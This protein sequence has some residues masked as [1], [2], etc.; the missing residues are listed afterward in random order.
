MPELLLELF[1]EEIPARMQRRAAEDLR[2]LVTDALVERGFLYEGARAYATPR[3]LA[4][5]VVGLPPE[6]KSVREERRGPR[7][8]APEAAIQGFLRSAGLPSL[9]QA[10]VEASPKGEFYM[11][12]I[13]RPGRRTTEV[14]AEILPPILRAFPWPKSMR[15]GAASS[16]A[17]ALRWVRPLHAI[18]CTFGPEGEDPDVVRFA[19]NGIES[20]DIT[21]GH[22]FH[23]PGPIRAKHFSDYAAS[24]ERA[25]VVLDADRRKDMILHDAR[26]LSFARGLDLVEDEGLLEEVAGLVEWPV[27]L[28]GTFDEVFL[29]MPPEVIRATIRANQKCFVTRPLP[30]RRGGQGGV[31]AKRDRSTL[32]GKVEGTMPL[33][34]TVL[35]RR[36]PPYPPLRGGRRSPAPSSSSPTSPPPTAGRR[37]SRG[38]SG[39]CG[40]GSRT[41]ASSGKR[42]SRSRWRTGW[43]S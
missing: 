26:D 37:W 34:G 25:R 17:G 18:L 39:W 8:G 27:T 38:T 5:H 31:R 13:E 28:M 4:L 29:A 32:F 41:P 40:R 23:A 43:R 14:L 11:A 7:V 12:V 2:N 1:S 30:P 19:V 35:T 10:R 6:G 21:F 36:T 15:W 33:R 9:D 24:L 16:E 22:R 42:T 20:G 3:R